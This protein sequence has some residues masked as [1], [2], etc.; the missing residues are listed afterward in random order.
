MPPSKR[1]VSGPKSGAILGQI[2]FSEALAT[3]VELKRSSTAPR[4]Q[5]RIAIPEEA[6]HQSEN[7][8]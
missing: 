1:L 4:E 5:Q 2:F 8:R 3:M 7:G 6:I